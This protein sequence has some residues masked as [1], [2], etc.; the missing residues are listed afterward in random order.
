MKSLLA[1]LAS[2]VVLCVAVLVQNTF[3]QANWVCSGPYMGCTA[4]TCTPAVGTCPPGGLGAGEPYSYAKY[5]PISVY[6]C[7]VPPG[8]GCDQNAVQGGFCAVIGYETFNMNGCQ[9]DLCGW[10]EQ[11]NQ[12]KNGP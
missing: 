12:C 7:T 2:S 11:V 1:C 6:S 10:V 4:E 3:G 9:N 8:T 5:V